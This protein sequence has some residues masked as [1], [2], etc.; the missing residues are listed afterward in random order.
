MKP[1]S[2]ALV[3]FLRTELLN[4]RRDANLTQEAMAEQLDVSTRAFSNL[5][6]GHSTFSLKTF[7]RFYLRFRPENPEAFWAELEHIIDTLDDETA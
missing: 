5:E 4:A 3:S 1:K 7:L 2:E 6:G